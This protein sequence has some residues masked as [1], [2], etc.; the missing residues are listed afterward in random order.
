[1]TSCLTFLY[2][3]IIIQ[4]MKETELQTPMKIITRLS[5]LKGALQKVL[6]AEAV[7]T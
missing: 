6:E 7:G 3:Y 4:R 2:L 1:M 5:N